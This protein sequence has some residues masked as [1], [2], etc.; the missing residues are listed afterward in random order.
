[1]ALYIADNLALFE[2][3]HVDEVMLVVQRLSN[4]VSE[5][6]SAVAN[7]MEQGTVEGLGMSLEGKV[8]V[9]SEAERFPATRLANG[10][11]VVALAILTKNLL[12]EVYNV[13]EE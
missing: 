3:Q 8:T 12:L 7:A 13:T 4:M 5:V 2:Y 9:V 11:I 6:G 10:S 1:M